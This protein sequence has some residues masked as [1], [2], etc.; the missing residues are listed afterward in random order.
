MQMT[1]KTEEKSN[2]VRITH[3]V[4][5]LK[6]KYQNAAK[7]A[8]ELGDLPKENEA[9]YIWLQGN[10]IFGD[11]FVQYI[12]ENELDVDSLTIISLSIAKN[13]IEAL[14]ELIV[15][16]WVL[17]IDLMLSGYFIRTE[18]IKHTHTIELLEKYVEENKDFKVFVSNTHQKIALMQLADGRK[19][20]FHGSANMKGSQNYE[21]LMIE[22]NPKLYDFNY[23]YFNQLKENQDGRI[24]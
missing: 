9:I 18:K 16:D 21:Q 10:F 19:I 1:K 6:V 24:R 11:F 22:N 12:T 20:V 2:F 13:T 23:N 7:L 17:N 5:D 3:E 4:K 8:S 14:N 15:Q